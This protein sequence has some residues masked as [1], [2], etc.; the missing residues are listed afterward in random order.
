M[1]KSSNI[2]AIKSD[3]LSSNYD[4]R[5]V[6]VN[7]ETGEILDDA[8]G[9]GYRSA[10]KAYAAYTYKHRDKSKDKQRKQEEKAIKKWW[11]DH[12]ELSED[13]EQ[14][15]F[16]I[17]KGSWGP[18]DKLDAKLLKTILKQENIESEYSPGKLLKV[19][20]KL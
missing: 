17:A 4:T 7:T 12:K 11:Q 14:I 3:S 10:Q 8:Q 1:T 16:E 2:K 9:Y 20:K 15:A 5:F 13:L 19:W 6:I 18:D